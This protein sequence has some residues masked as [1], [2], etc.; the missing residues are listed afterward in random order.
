M[1]QRPRVHSLFSAKEP[2][3]A[4]QLF[5]LPTP[6]VLLSGAKCPALLHGQPASPAR[7]PFFFRLHLPHYSSRF[8]ECPQARFTSGIRPEPSARRLQPAASSYAPRVVGRSS[9]PGQRRARFRQPNGARRPVPATPPL[10]QRVDCML[11]VSPRHTRRKIARRLVR[12][13][14]APHATR[15]KILRRK[16]L[17]LIA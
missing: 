6:A 16:R 9:S 12:G 7:P 8:S 13:S 5:L 11:L 4:L 3:A 15:G 14:V 2:Q 17:L 1:P 10:A